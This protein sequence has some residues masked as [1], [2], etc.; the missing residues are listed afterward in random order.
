MFAT[1]D[2]C[3]C[4]PQPG[5]TRQAPGAHHVAPATASQPTGHRTLPGVGAPPRAC[6]CALQESTA[7][8]AAFALLVTRE[9]DCPRRLRVLEP[10]CRDLW[11]AVP[12]LAHPELLE[13]VFWGDRRRRWGTL[14]L[15]CGKEGTDFYDRLAAW[16][17]AFEEGAKSCCAGTLPEGEFSI[18]A[19]GHSTGRPFAMIFSQRVPNLAGIIGMESSPLRR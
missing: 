5:R 12:I 19:H 13:G 2:R 6:P 16:P 8:A 15:P 7:G 10:Y 4:V 11:R 3:P 9:R 17:V 18:Y 1:S 14:T